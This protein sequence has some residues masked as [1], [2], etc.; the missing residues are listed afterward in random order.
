MRLRPCMQRR[1]LGDG[2][3]EEE[4]QEIKRRIQLGHQLPSLPWPP[5]PLPGACELG[6]KE[7][8]FEGKD[9]SCF[10]KDY[11]RKKKKNLWGAIR[12]PAPLGLILCPSLGKGQV[13]SGNADT[14]GRD[15]ETCHHPLGQM[16]T[17]WLV[18]R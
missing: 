7:Q 11:G 18:P 17:K 3:E 13:L 12:S 4:E 5:P 6:R 1:Y 8:L 15:G 2:R 9:I 16:S 10:P 14:P